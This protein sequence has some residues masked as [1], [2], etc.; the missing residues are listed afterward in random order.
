MLNLFRIEP[1][2]DSIDTIPIPSRLINM[3]IGRSGHIELDDY[4]YCI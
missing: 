2:F 4:W 3:R 1:V